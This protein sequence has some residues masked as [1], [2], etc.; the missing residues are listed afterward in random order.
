MGLEDCLRSS[1]K[2]SLAEAIIRPLLHLPYDIRVSGV[3]IFDSIPKP[4]IVA[5]NHARLADGF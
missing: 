3:E 5:C 4:Y 1:W 2:R